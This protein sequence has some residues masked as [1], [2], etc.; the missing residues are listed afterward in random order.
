ML[1]TLGA[2]RL[3][4]ACGRETLVPVLVLMLVCNNNNNNNN[5]NNFL[6]YF[7]IYTWHYLITIV[8]YKI[9]NTSSFVKCLISIVHYN[10]EKSS[11]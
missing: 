7:H 10:E 6:R 4:D 1:A 3:S 9:S 11:N 5:N 8:N 2:C